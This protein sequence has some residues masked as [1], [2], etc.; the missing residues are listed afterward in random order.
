MSKIIQ[1]NLIFFFTV[2]TLDRFNLVAPLKIIS[3]NLIHQCFMIPISFEKSLQMLV[4]FSSLLIV[5][6]ACEGESSNNTRESSSQNSSQS[7][8]TSSDGVVSVVQNNGQATITCSP[9]GTGT[10]TV[11]GNVT[12][13]NGEASSGGTFTCE[14]GQLRRQ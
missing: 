5:T 12:T 10:A 4:F 2:L 13:V 8:T 3:C 6:T 14:N 1:C 11:A 9:T 7:A